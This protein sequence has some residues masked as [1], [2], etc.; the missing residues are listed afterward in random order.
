MSFFIAPSYQTRRCVRYDLHETYAIDPDE[1]I[2][3]ISYFSSS[4]SGGI[5]LFMQTCRRK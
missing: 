2:K 5:V 3:L 1:I 4:E